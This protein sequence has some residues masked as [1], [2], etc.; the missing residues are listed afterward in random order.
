MG[1]CA[2]LRRGEVDSPP[3]ARLPGEACVL[4]LLAQLFA[5]MAQYLESGQVVM[6]LRPFSLSM[7][8]VASPVLTTINDTP[9]IVTSQWFLAV[10]FSEE[11]RNP[12]KSRRT[13]PRLSLAEH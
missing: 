4:R 13:G 2:S 10:I 1:D 8:T 5:V 6:H 7:E 9:V 12:C 3:A 11:S